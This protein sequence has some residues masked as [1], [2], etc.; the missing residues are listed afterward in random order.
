MLNKSIG[1]MHCTIKH[2]FL[3][4]DVKIYLFRVI[5]L[6]NIY[7][8]IAT[9][10]KE[11]TLIPCHCIIMILYNFD[12]LAYDLLSVNESSTIYYIVTYSD[13]PQNNLS[14]LDKEWGEEVVVVEVDVRLLRPQWSQLLRGQQELE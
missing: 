7:H 14:W 12:N 1:T 11:L 8:C 13:F 6:F 3:Y 10:E 5:T 9:T 2:T 4:T